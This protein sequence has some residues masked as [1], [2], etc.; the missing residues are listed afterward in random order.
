M[1]NR[2][3]Q[4]SSSPEAKFFLDKFNKR[5]NLM[6]YH[7][8]RI[9]CF[10]FGCLGQHDRINNH[11]GLKVVVFMSPTDNRQLNLI[12]PSENLIFLSSP[13]FKIPDQYKVKDVRIETQ[14]YSIFKPSRLGNKIYSHIGNMGRSRIFKFDELMKLQ[15]K[16]DWEIIFGMSKTG[17]DTY[18]SPI[19]LKNRFYDNCFVNINLSNGAG[20]T[21]IRELAKMG[22]RTIT[23]LSNDYP[24]TINY[25]D[26][27]HII[28]LIKEES[29]KIGTIQPDLMSGY[30]YTGD[31][32]LTADFWI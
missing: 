32:W 15:D 25:V 17:A 3:I 8:P 28:E 6:E 14:D 13:F 29:K 19:N 4:S 27:G 23:N 1:I 7:N 5:W 12:K 9:P 30:R 24:C 22:R 31:E 18:L 16:L 21:T 2:I 26:H 11:E 10:F 20:E